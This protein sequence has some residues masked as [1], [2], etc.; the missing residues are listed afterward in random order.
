MSDR[1]RLILAT[2]ETIY[3]EPNQACFVVEMNGDCNQLLRNGTSQFYSALDTSSVTDIS[4][5]L[6]NALG[7]TYVKFKDN[8]FSKCTNASTIINSGSTQLQHLD[9]INCDLSNALSS[10]SLASK[11]VL[12]ENI[13]SFDFTDS[14][15]PWYYMYR[16][17]YM[18]PNLKTGSFK[19]VNFNYPYSRGVTF[20][21]AFE[22][23]PNLESVDF[24]G[25]NLSNTTNM[26]KMF[27]QCPK[28]TS[29]SFA[30]ADLSKVTSM[31]YMFGY[32]TSLKSLTITG[33]LNSSLSPFYTFAGVETSGTFYYDTDST[34]TKLKSVLPSKWKA[35]KI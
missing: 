13:V 33:S 12:P 18:F 4:L 2:G 14:I 35:V 10:E 25:A 29:M 22:Q 8:D 15:L 17:C 6:D 27:F 11:L 9:M 31:N 21:E 5:L 19:N 23:C 16:F 7:L 20:E 30:G 24:T 3:L 32:C 34:Y 1:R 28:L 26:N